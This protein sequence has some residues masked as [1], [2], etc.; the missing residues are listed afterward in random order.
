MAPY[1]WPLWSIK[2][3]GH[4]DWSSPFI[5]ICLSLLLLKM[6]MIPEKKKKNGSSPY[7]F[8]HIFCQCPSIL[9]SSRSGDI[10][11]AYPVV[12]PWWDEWQYHRSTPMMSQIYCYSSV[13]LLFALWFCVISFTCTRRW[14]FLLARLPVF[15]LSGDGVLLYI[16]KMTFGFPRS[17]P[18]ES[19]GRVCAWDTWARR[20]WYLLM[21]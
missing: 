7:V 11:S 13:N 3:H 12:V 21:Y 16:M 4:Y 14:I 1:S 5:H 2:H 9:F 10:S 20:S 8:Q 15:L 18:P 19:R 17:T 6:H